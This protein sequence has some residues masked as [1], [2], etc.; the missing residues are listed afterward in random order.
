MIKPIF[1][2]VKLTTNITLDIKL[3]EDLLVTCSNNDTVLELFGS[4]QKRSGH[5]LVAMEGITMGSYKFILSSNFIIEEI[6]LKISFVFS[7]YYL[8]DRCDNRLII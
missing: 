3:V 8:K 2:R 1:L 4:Q 7:A 6:L 5:Y